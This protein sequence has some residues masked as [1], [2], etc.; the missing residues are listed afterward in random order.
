MIFDE[1]KLLFIKCKVAQA[2]IPEVREDIEI[3][4]ILEN[5][6][7]ITLGSKYLRVLRKRK[8]KYR[9]SAIT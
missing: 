4:D 1:L 2:K 7:L 3:K 5:K 6:F 8:R 9:V